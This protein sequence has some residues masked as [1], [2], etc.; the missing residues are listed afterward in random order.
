[1][2]KLRIERKPKNGTNTSTA[3]TETPPAPALESDCF[4][5]ENV[6]L[7]QMGKDLADADLD[8]PLGDNVIGFIGKAGVGKTTLSEI[9]AGTRRM[10]PPAA[11][12]ANVGDNDRFGVRVHRANGMV[13]LDTSAVLSGILP[14][15]K[16]SSGSVS[17]SSF[18]VRHN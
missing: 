16:A 2:K 18:Y 1:M 6:P 17:L 12:D 5:V 4:T 11:S 9:V 10:S 3:S 15:L 8:A 14:P 13:I 7:L